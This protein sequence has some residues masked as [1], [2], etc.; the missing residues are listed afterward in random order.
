M[1]FGGF[2][3][4]L[5]VIGAFT[6]NSGEKFA[7]SLDAPIQ[8]ATNQFNL[9]EG[10]INTAANFFQRALSGD[11]GTLNE[12]LSPQVSTTLSQYDTA[13]K[14]ASQFTPRGGGASQVMSELPFKKVGVY[15]NALAGARGSAAGGLMGA[16]QAGGGMA[17]NMLN[18]LYGTKMNALNLGQEQ[19][20]FNAQNMTSFGKALGAMMMGGTG[21]GGFLA[22]L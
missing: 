4:T 8:S 17:G 15:G 1:S 7:K 18:T 20:A 2:L 12:L 16:G 9:G 3:N 6:N 10:R 14:A 11:R 21:A 5:P 13:A 22:A 19:T